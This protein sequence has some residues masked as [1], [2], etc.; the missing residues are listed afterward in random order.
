[1][2]G[3]AMGVLEGSSRRVGLVHQ[4]ASQGQFTA[5]RRKCLLWRCA[6]V[7]ERLRCEPWRPWGWFTAAPVGTEP[8][9][10]QREQLE[11]PREFTDH[12]EYRL[13]LY[14]IARRL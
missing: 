14:Q 8:R 9:R 7:C 2:A 6:L 11:I 5:L 13:G 12:A 3:A 4:T 10:E 1:M